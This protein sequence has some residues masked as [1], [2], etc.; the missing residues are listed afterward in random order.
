MQSC[1]IPHPGI[2]AVGRN[3]GRKKEERDDY[4]H[5]EQQDE[6][7]EGRRLGWEN[8]KKSWKNVFIPP[9]P[10]FPGNVAQ[11]IPSL[12]PGFWD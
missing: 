6:I 8:K 5:T 4:G 3:G 1:G 10:T 2:P 9:D 7:P 11:V 12:T